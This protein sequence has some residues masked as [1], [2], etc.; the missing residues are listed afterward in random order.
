V[1]WSQNIRAIDDEWAQGPVLRLMIGHSVHRTLHLADI[2]DV[3]TWLNKMKQALNGE[4][5]SS[6]MVRKELQAMQ[7]SREK[8]TLEPLSAPSS[9]SDALACVVE[10][11]RENDL[12]ISQPSAGALTRPLA[13]GERLALSFA[14]SRGLCTGEARVLGR[15][16]LPSGGNKL[17]FGYRLSMPERLDV[18]DRRGHRRIPLDR[19]VAPH[20]HLMTLPGETTDV[21]CA[22]ISGSIV[23]ISLSG[24]QVKLDGSAGPVNPGSK[25]ILNADFPLPVGTISHPVKVVRFDHDPQT[26]VT[27]LGLK[28]ESP[29]PNLPQFLTAYESRM[30]R[31]G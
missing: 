9:S 14:S 24:M 17:F 27:R 22:S 29:V 30:A 18:L 2:G 6:A 5:G 11:V 25:L 26:G 10:Q 21:L 28:F 4:A 8:L 23:E 12:V 3:G 15:I 13:T 16:K 19:G 7:R 1:E 31:R 20:V